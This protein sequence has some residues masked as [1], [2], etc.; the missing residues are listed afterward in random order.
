MTLQLLT[1]PDD[2]QAWPGW[3]TERFCSGQLP[4][5]VQE[6]HLLGGAA[7]A[8]AKPAD[9]DVILSPQRQQDVADHGLQVLTTAELQHLFAYPDSLL[10]LHGYLCVCGGEIWSPLWT[11]AIEADGLPTANSA[12]QIWHHAETQKFVPPATPLA[13]PTTAERRRWSLR[14][15]IV[16]AAAAVLMAVILRPQDSPQFSLRTPAVLAAETTSPQ[17][18]L[19]QLADAGNAWFDQ[20]PRDARQLA[21]LLQAVSRD[22]ELLIQAPPAILTAAT[23][24]PRTPGDPVTQA[25]WF[26]AKCRKWQAE[27]DATLAKLESGSLDFPTAQA[28]ADRIMMK[29]VTVLQAGPA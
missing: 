1:I 21:A 4:L 17:Q 27:I 20:H 22:C 16:V 26:T 12:A 5:L 11:T 19:N 18:W 15:A 13:A 10:Q 29:L 9:P 2:P 14:L 7:A 3:L 24:T 25:A 28:E 6:L 23:L 8:A